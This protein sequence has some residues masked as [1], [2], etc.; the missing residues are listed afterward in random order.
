MT[1]SFNQASDSAKVGF[2]SQNTYAETIVNIPGDVQLTVE[3]D[4]PPSKKYKI[5][6]QN[7][8]NGNP[9]VARK[10]LWDAMMEG[11]LY[12]D[13]LFH[14]LVAMLSDRT[15]QQFT[16]EE[17]DQLRR[18]RLHD[19][20][21]GGDPW[22][23]GIRFVYQLLGPA[24]SSAK[25]KSAATDTRD[26]LKQFHKLGGEQRE[27]LRP[28]LELFVTGRLKDDL[29]LE[30]VQ[31]AGDRQHLGNRRGRAWMFFQPV[32]AEAILPGTSPAWITRA[33]Q[34]KLQIGAVTLALTGGY[35]AWQLLWHGIA[36]GVLGY[37]AVLG[38]SIVAARADAEWS[39]LTGRRRQKDEQFRAP[40][41]PAASPSG[42]KIADRVD[43]LFRR[44]FGRQAEDK[45]ERKRW[46]D[47]VTGFRRFYRDEIIG[48]CRASGVA[49][50]YEMAWLIRY[51]T[52]QLKKLWQRGAL[53]DYRQELLPR[54]GTAAVRQIGL[55]AAILGSLWTVI[56]L[57]AYPVTDALGSIVAL[58][59]AIGTWRCWLRITLERRRYAADREERDR[60]QADI[61][62]EF[63]RWCKVLEARPKDEEMAAW[64]ECDRTVLLAM[65]LDHFGLSR[66]QLNAHALVEE[67]AVGVKRAR[68]EGG[69]VR[70]GGYR[71]L[72]FLL[73]GDGVRQVRASLD[74]MKG[75]LTV[76]ERTS[77]RY[78]A[79]VSVC[80]VKETGRGQTFELRL[81]AGDPIKVRV[82]E[83]D[84]EA[85]SDDDRG[86][87]PVAEEPENVD[88]DV[89][90]VSN[91]LHIL[92]GVAAEG[93]RWLRQR[94]WAP[95]GS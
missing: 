35:L 69:P 59:A 5:G 39:F 52:R 64:L 58:T 20:G 61:D 91:T 68:I 87:S 4:D 70:C 95:A 22:A 43:A 3:A 38:G 60:R 94:D 17:V 36:F 33:D 2:Q 8:K 66:S 49:D 89:A 34:R 88:L 86:E 83:A 74:F 32:P 6:V 19:V 78:D 79:I 44:Y 24:L 7:L 48:M 18:F 13:V 72:M 27:L 45:D 53:Y 73:A 93:R 26:L 57:H 16:K 1:T 11:W 92:E 41:S 63:E 28:H 84:P 76:R 82:R 15:V 80:V 9:A 30:E 12:S 85:I 54:P 51:Q 71:I 56:S 47:A 55:A 50:A 81:K 37:V 75:I 14:W 46:E 23:E 31:L 62:K 21:S 77:Y 29:W 40:G 42:D 10:Y 65:M 25:P 67:A 90:S